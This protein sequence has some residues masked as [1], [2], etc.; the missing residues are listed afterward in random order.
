[1]KQGKPWTGQFPS[2][3]F[4]LHPSHAEI[5]AINPTHKGSFKKPTLVRTTNIQTN[6]LQYVSQHCS[7][8]LHEV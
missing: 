3:N 7:N 5:N 6:K 8:K 4:L 1:M 2:K